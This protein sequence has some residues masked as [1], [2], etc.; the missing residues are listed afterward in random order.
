[1]NSKNTT[2]MGFRRMF[3]LFSLLFVIGQLFAQTSVFVSSSATDDSGDGS[4]WATAKKTIAAGIEAVGTSGT[5]YVKA[6]DY[7][8][9][10]EFTIPVGVIVKG[11]YQQI[12]EGADT[13]LR[14]LPGVNSHWTDNTWCTI[15]SGYGNHRIATVKGQL[16]GCVVRMGYTYTIGGG[17][18][19]DGGTA[20]Y[21]II[22]EC[23]AIN[24]D[25]FD[26]EGGGVYIRNNGVLINSVVTECRADNGVGVAGEDGSLINNTITR[27]A[28]ISCGYVV[29]IDGNYYDAVLIGTQCWMKQNL[30]VTRFPDGNSIPLGTAYQTTPCYYEYSSLNIAQYGLLYNWYA[31]MN[32]ASSSN[33][34]PSGVQ[35]ICPDGWHVP[36]YAE[37]DQLVNYVS[38]QPANSCDGNQEYYAKSLAAK[39]VWNTNNG[40]S[41]YVGANYNT[42]W[43]STNNRTRFTALPAGRW[44][45]G[46][47]YANSETW[48]WTSRQ[49][50]ETSAYYRN[51]GSSSRSLYNSNTDKRLGYS[52]RCLRDANLANTEDQT[53][54]VITTSAV[55]GVS[56]IT[57]RG[58]GN[59]T[60]DGGSVV[61]ARGVCWGTSENPTVSGNH[62]TDGNGVGNFTSTM[63]GLEAN[64][65][66]Y[67]RAYATN[68]IG[69]A[70]GENVS[71]TTAGQPCPGAPTVTDVDGNT[72]NTV[73]IGNQCWMKE[74]LRTK[75]YVSGGAAVDFKYPNEQP[76]TQ[77]TYGLLY[78]WATMMNGANSSNGNPS[79]VQGICPAGWHLPS[80]A[81]WDQLATY[82]GGQ[83]V[84][85]CDNNSSSIAK[86]LA[87]TSGWTTYSY[88]SCYPGYDQGGNN[89]TGFSA[90]PA[91]YYNSSYS[92]FGVAVYWWSATQSND[93]YAYRAR[94][95]YSSYDLYRT[96]V[97]KTNYFSVRCLK[98]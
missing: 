92:D 17:L 43:Q 5:V 38:S 32:N 31:V 44:D 4:S 91:G 3:F 51:I 37:W 67:V 11:G 27:N 75:H 20:R 63:S 16:D 18:L 21:C 71:F 86:A 62:T 69:T 42:Y 13:T 8:T 25:D 39:S 87:S 14:R 48:F 77:S 40:S 15:I 49:S 2:Y 12:S 94:L 19:L 88:S 93:T 54:P 6:G 59:I 84:L 76:S 97:Y 79:Y 22:K 10:E 56:A 28:P 7:S 64:T 61:T 46:L 45:Q 58:G 65:T 26:A 34:N 80:N 73:L 83:A 74:N 1:M 55:A 35:G 33:G 57:A 95:H 90:M 98:D 78:N 36:S 85:R 29:D 52:V 23:D 50:S 89:A 60:S 30:R 9:T 66:Y 82:V 47:S 96:D 81:E 41:C 24:D 68:A 72:Y 53:V 70:Y